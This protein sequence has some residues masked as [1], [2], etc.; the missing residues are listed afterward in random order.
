MENSSDVVES[1]FNL[2][3]VN[4]LEKLKTISKNRI[5]IIDKSGYVKYDSASDTK[6]SHKFRQEVLEAFKYSE[7]FSVRES[8]TLNEKLIYYS[9]RY[10]ENYVIR[11]ADSYEVL[12]Q[13][14]RTQL[15]IKIITYIILNIFLFIAYKLILR[16][17]FFDKL[18]N[19]RKV[20]ESGKKAK[21]LYLEEDKDLVEFWH[22]I[23]DWQNNNIRNIEKL[24]EE[25]SKLNQIFSVIDISILVID[26]KEKIISSNRSFEINF[27]NDIHGEKYYEKIKYLKIN[28]L[29]KE[30]LLEKEPITR[31]LHIQETGKT[32]L[33]KGRYDESK[34]FYI[35]SLKDITMSKEREKIEKRFISNVSHELKT[36]LT[37]IKG[38][39]IALEEE[40]DPMMKKSFLDIV[41]NNILKMEN[42]IMDFLNLQKVES[43]KALNI[44]PCSVH[45]ILDE[46]ISDMENI[47]KDKNVKINKKIDTLE[48]DG[49]VNLDKEKIKIVI[50]NLIENSINYNDKEIPIIDI[51]L[52][53]SNKHFTIIV[54]DNG[55]GISDKDKTHI[56]DRFYRVDK[57]RTSNKGGTGLGL[58]II[59]EITDIYAGKI[60]LI[61]NETDGTEIKIRVL[62]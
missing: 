25:K 50:K 30:L 45:E 5:T 55:I 20:V 51:S 35:L 24:K 23:K 17:Y 44:Y 41:N 60:D 38:Y 59:K 7:G 19:M 34:G 42:I 14:I 31:E 4:N 40:N 10:N 33:T 27:F 36:P 21:E 28:R 37:N 11:V 2:N 15:L 56:F 54:K 46:V 58:S 16:K 9:R 22:V 47:I 49:F 18:T 62:K 6:E 39:L 3:G 57:A 53:E 52:E 48:E 29:V 32:Y 43:Q 8:S 1:F 26:E 61:S 12:E 13:S